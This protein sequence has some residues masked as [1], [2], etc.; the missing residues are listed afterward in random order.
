M[1]QFRYWEEY[2]NFRG[3]IYVLIIDYIFMEKLKLQLIALFFFF[4]LLFSGITVGGLNQNGIVNL[5]SDE[6]LFYTGEK[7]SDNFYFVHITDTHLLHRLFDRNETSKKRLDSVLDYIIS[8]DEK[9]A[10]AVITGDLVEWGSSV[11][12][13]MNY[14][15]LMKCFYEKDSQYYADSNYSIPV[16]FTPGN[17]DYY[18]DW[19]LINYHRFV[20][21]N[22]V[23][24]NDRYVVNYENLSLF[25]VDSGGHYILRPKE[26]LDVLGSGLTNRDIKW[27]EDVLSSY[28]SRHK[29]IL[30]HFPAVNW[31]DES[32]EMN[33]VIARNRELFVELCEEYDVDLVLVG[34][35]HSSVVF[36]G[37]ENVYDDLPLNCSQYPPLHVQTDDCKQG[38]HYR[39]ITI[40]GD[41]IWLDS[42]MEI[43]VASVDLK[44]IGML[45]NSLERVQPVIPIDLFTYAPHNNDI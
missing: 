7:I 34:H 15:T 41:D 43:H 32:G 16:Y 18:F 23:L 42:C 17:H 36:D 2:R 6:R 26:W 39:N 38:C 12:G 22:H 37:D 29:I 10:F 27:L 3:K 9:P 8:F 28:S 20:D 13:S 40:L 11:S 25:F 24:E 21:R 4:I 45:S 1:T 35:T 19:N 30:M 14:R 33:G 44:N 31:R 5:E